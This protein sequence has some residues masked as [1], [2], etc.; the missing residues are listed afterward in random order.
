LL[1]EKDKRRQALRRDLAA[2]KVAGDLTQY[3][4]LV[5]VARRHYPELLG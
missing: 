5:E 3:R 1:A 2:A 4:Q